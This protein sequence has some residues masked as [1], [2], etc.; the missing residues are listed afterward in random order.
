MPRPFLTASWSNLSLLTYAVRPALLQPRV[1]PGLELE[2]RDGDAFVSLVA[3]DFM[4][5]RVLGLSWPGYRYFAELNLRFYVR[6]GADRGVVF[7]REIVPQRL[8][9]WLARLLYNEPYVAAPLES[10]ILDEGSTVTAERRLLWQGQSYRISVTGAR[11]AMQPE[12]TSTEHFFKEHHWGY[13]IDR[14]GGAL[15]YHVEHPVWAVYPVQSYELDFDWAHVYG[16]QWQC[17]QNQKPCS[18][19]LAVGSPVLVFPKARPAPASL[20][21]AQAPI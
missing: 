18:A 3:F 21:L 20:Q 1:P 17:L 7:I 14:R 9:A 19:V 6:H 10:K 8:V 15:C 2:V 13:G 5:T 11:P 12:E 4:D 16:P